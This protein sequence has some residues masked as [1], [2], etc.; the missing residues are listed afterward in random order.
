MQS[1]DGVVVVGVMYS[2]ECNGGVSLR[3][4]LEC[5]LTVETAM[6]DSRLPSPS[7]SSW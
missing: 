4:H 3:W 6:A 2:C 1:G 5:S 7:R